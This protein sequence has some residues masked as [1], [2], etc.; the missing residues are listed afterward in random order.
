[1]LEKLMEACLGELSYL[2]SRVNLY[3]GI[4]QTVGYVYAHFSFYA[5]SIKCSSIFSRPVFDISF[6]LLS[7][8]KYLCPLLYPEEP[9]T[10][11][12]ASPPPIPPNPVTHVTFP[13]E[14]TA[15]T[16]L[17]IQLQDL[18]D[19]FEDSK[20][21]R[22][23][24][25]LSDS[26]IGR[27]IYHEEVRERMIFIADRQIAKSI[28]SAVQNDGDIL[29]LYRAQER[30]AEQ[31]H[32]L[33]RRLGGLEGSNATF[34][35]DIASKLEPE[36][37]DDHL[38]ARLLEYNCS[39]QDVD[40]GSQAGPSTVAARQNDVSVRMVLCEACTEA[41]FIFD[42]VKL[43]C[44]HDYCGECLQDLFTGCLTDETLFPPRCCRQPI[45][46][47]SVQAFMTHGL[48]AAF[49][50]RE[51]EMSTLNRIYCIS[52]A[53]SSFIPPN[54]I[55]DDKATCPECNSVTCTICKSAAHPGDCPQDTALQELQTTA[56]A[57]GWKRCFS[58]RRF[59]ELEL[60]CNH[61]T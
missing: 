37:P 23:A 35:S 61:I 34:D 40:P 60:G 2:C 52:S 38:M 9:T 43:P 47:D 50:K 3:C 53:C 4:I 27:E 11:T 5:S 18:H 15:A 16:A 55:A 20:G 58:C 17:H 51:V 24:D 36:E 32:E 48:V 25:Q 54:R 49:K 46:L 7:S 13:D 26:D 39:Y 28:E 29:A 31:D 22:R 14:D 10:H 56:E 1:M 21:K 6:F 42:V 19:L 59:V 33:A 45:A 12:M 41:K 8:Y 30:Q 57:S 44:K